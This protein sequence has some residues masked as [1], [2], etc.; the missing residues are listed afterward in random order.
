MQRFSWVAAL[1][2]ATVWT[3]VAFGQAPAS[4]LP[5]GPGT[6]TI[7]PPLPEQQRSA[8]PPP[9]VPATPPPVPL[10]PG[11]EPALEPA[12]EPLTLDVEKPLPVATQQE[13]D[14]NLQCQGLMDAAVRVAAV[15]KIVTVPLNPQTALDLLQ[16]ALLK[17]VEQAA[18]DQGLSRE[19]IMQRS[20]SAV[21]G[22]LPALKAQ[23]GKFIRMVR[24]Q[25]ERD[26]ET[27]RLQEAVCTVLIARLVGERGPAD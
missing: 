3:G 21:S 15:R 13:I 2:A 10:E 24:G 12:S 27:I 26:I 4:S 8:P 22:A 19:T 16:A 7:K 23:A 9:V 17:T 25:R 14:R 18:T 20:K 6:E 1:A 11:L 5:T